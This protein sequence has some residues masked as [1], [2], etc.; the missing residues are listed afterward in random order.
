[1]IMY[2]ECYSKHCDSYYTIII[3]YN[4]CLGAHIIICSCMFAKCMFL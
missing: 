2:G 4:E 3:F 1:M